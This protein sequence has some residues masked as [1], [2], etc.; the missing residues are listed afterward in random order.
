LE[1]WCCFIDVSESADQRRRFVC[2]FGEGDPMNWKFKAALLVVATGFWNG[3]ALTAQI[4][5]YDPITGI[6]TV[7][8][9]RSD[10][11][12]DLV[13]IFIEG[14]DVSVAGCTLCDGDNL[15]GTDVASASTWTVGYSAG[16]TQWIRTNPLSGGGFVGSIGEYFIDGTGAQ[17]A[18]PV[19]VPPF[20]DFP[21]PGMGIAVYPT[22]L[23]ASD[24]GN[25]TYASDDGTVVVEPFPFC[26]GCGNNDPPEAQNDSYDA[27]LGSVLDV[28]APGVLGN[29]F[30]PNGDQLFASILSSPTLGN[31]TLNLDGSFSYAA[32]SV[33]SVPVGTVDSFSYIVEDGEAT[34]DV[35]TV[36]I[37][38]TVPEPAGLG[39]PMGCVALALVSL[40]K[41][42]LRRRTR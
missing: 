5:N 16:A 40:R 39:L 21:D 10:L 20:F 11:I 30:D 2:S 29:D 41:R 6:V 26:L 9:E 1:R 4:V 3:P 24:F 18:W 31:V 38:L 27:L 23:G 37:T 14:P 28:V 36:N 35:G 22:D 25:V 17:Q 32:P 7:D 33:G 34:F 15:P 19:D 8:T 12:N 13:A 42:S